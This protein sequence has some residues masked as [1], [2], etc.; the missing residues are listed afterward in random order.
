M[1]PSLTFT[2]LVAASLALIPLTGRGQN[3]EDKPA[4]KISSAG[5][6]QEPS[7]SPTK[8][9]QAEARRLAREKRTREE[10]SLRLERERQCVIK[11]VMTDAEITRC[12]E[13]WR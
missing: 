4:E 3:A 9:E 12:K 10:E 11:P 5:Q 13:V 6:M 2:F 1:R 8:E 7:E